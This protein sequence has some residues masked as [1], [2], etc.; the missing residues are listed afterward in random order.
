MKFFLLLAA[1]LTRLLAITP[2]PLLHGLAWPLGQLMY[3]LPWQKHRVIRTNL[4][5]CFPSLS[6]AERK[7]LHRAYLVEQ[8]RLVVEAGAVFHWSVERIEARLQI[9]GWD[10]VEAA[11]ERGQG[12]MFVSGHV[13]N[14]ELLN[15]FISSRLPLATLYRKPD[16][17]ALDVFICRPRQRFGGSV[18][19]GGSPALRGMLAQLRRGQA[20][21][22]AADI[23]PKRGE[24]VFVPFLG[25]PAL[26]MTLVNRLA[27][28]TGCA[29]I[30]C[31]GLR[32]P[33]GQGWQFRF[34]EAPALIADADPVLAMSA[35]NRWLGKVVER[36][37]AQ[38]LWLYKR[39]SRQPDASKPY[40]KT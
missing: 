7:R 13:G 31:S 22:V 40:R 32:R 14:W 39:F 4:A 37:P 18:V 5:L 19:P 12:V 26:T 16:Q 38:Y 3:W 30:F 25:Q 29:V 17:P 6:A 9:E 1:M 11:A 21:A 20:V 23:Q 34:E 35:M 36:A 33:R 27:Q 24:G 2:L 10:L 8:L 28:K 15:L